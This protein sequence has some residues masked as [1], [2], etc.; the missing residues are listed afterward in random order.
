MLQYIC[1]TVLTVMSQS[2]IK[3]QREGTLRECHTFPRASFSLDDV[4]NNTL[5]P[6]ADTTPNFFFAP[7]DTGFLIAI[8]DYIHVTHRKTLKTLP[9]LT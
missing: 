8:V 6:S 7:V 2:L 3:I 5:A 1:R 4:P 9:F